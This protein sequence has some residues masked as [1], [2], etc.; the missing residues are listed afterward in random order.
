MP[1]RLHVPGER[2]R[3]LRWTVHDPRSRYGYGVL[4]Y[5]NNPSGDIL[6]GATF[7]MLRHHGAWL[8][9]DNPDR[10]RRAL[11]LMPDEDLGGHDPLPDDTSKSAGS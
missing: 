11:G 5:R 2:P 8:E 1:Y 4:V 9:T 3:A 7:R 10:A 6:D